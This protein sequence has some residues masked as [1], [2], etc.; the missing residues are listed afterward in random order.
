MTIDP[1]QN[2]RKCNFTSLP[3]PSLLLF[4]GERGK[5]KGINIE[6]LAQIRDSIF[7]RVN[8]LRI[9]SFLFSW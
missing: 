5:N 1:R 7:L 9:V 2:G 6:W 3:L 8:D 4:V